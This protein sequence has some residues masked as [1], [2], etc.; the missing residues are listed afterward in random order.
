[1]KKLIYLFTLGVGF[2]S[3]SVDSL[4][5]TENLLTADAS[6]KNQMT[7]EFEIPVGICAGVPAEFKL[8]APVG[9]NLQVQQYNEISGE[10]EQ[11]YKTP[12]STSN[13]QNFSL[14][15][16]SADTYQ[17]RYKAGSGGF[18]NAMD[19][20]V[21][22]CGCDESFTYVDNQDG[23]YTFTYIAGED[24]EDAEVV[25][26]F[27]Q[28]AYVSGLSDEFS[29]NGNNGQTYE[30]TMDLKECDVLNYTVTLQPTCSGNS[31]KSNVWTDFKVKDVSKK[32]N[33]EDKF[34]ASCN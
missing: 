26:T 20:R 10:W 24:M 16:P 5:S 32:A 27:A 3:C 2:T 6:L 14:T 28:G 29:Q 30:A 33:E 11:V 8:N 21:A 4:D 7:N 18:S 1:M 23:T 15:F 13:P 34:V 9:S 17:L 12:N 25:F 22:N 31:A 19:V